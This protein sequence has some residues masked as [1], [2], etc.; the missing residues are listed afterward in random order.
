[1]Q[2]ET[3]LHTI[4]LL[5]GP[6]NSGKTHFCK[7][8]LIPGL[9]K[10]YDKLNIQY[11]SSDDIRRKLNNNPNLGKYDSKMI[12]ASHQA[13]R[14]LYHDLDMVT[15]FP[16]NCHFAIVDTTGL[17]NDFRND[18]IEIAKKNHYNIDLILFNYSDYGNFFKYGGDHKIIERHIKTL[19]TQTLKEL[20]KEYRKRHYI[21]EITN[22]INIKINDIEMYKNNLLDSNKKY[23]IIG[24]VH[25]SVDEVKKLITN[26]GYLIENDLIKNSDTTLNTEII[27]V[28]DLIDK[29]NKTKETVEFF[30]INIDKVKLVSGN[31]DFAIKRL[32][33]GEQSE[34]AYETGFIDQF[35]TSYK[36]LKADQDLKNKFLEVESRMVPYYHYIADDTVSRS[37]YIMHSPC[38]MKFVGKHSWDAIKFQ[39]YMVLDRKNNQKP[40]DIIDI[41]KDSYSMPYLVTGHFAFKDEYNGSRYNNNRL[42]ID[43]GCI[44]GN[45]LTG[46]LLGKKMFYPK[47]FYVS[48][49]KKQ[50][51][52]N[53]SLEYFE[54]PKI[55]EKVLES[56]RPDQIK[57]IQSIVNNKINFISGTISPADRYRDYN[58][59]DLES[60]K[61]GLEY[62]FKFDETM[63]LSIQPKYMGSR[64][65]IYL[66]HNVDSCYAV[67]RNGYKIG[68][69]FMTKIYM[70]LINKFK[71]YMTH[72]KVKMMIIDSELMPWSAIGA[73]LIEKSFKTIDYALNKE[74]DILKSTGFE[75]EYQKLV[76]KMQSTTFPQ[77]Y[78]KKSNKELNDQYGGAVYQTYKDL[79]DEMKTHISVDELMEGAKL[80]H[81]QIEIYGK[82]Q[83]VHIKPF[84]ILKIIYEDETEV[85]PTGQI[86]IF[87]MVSDDTQYVVD[88]SHGFDQCLIEAS[89]YFDKLTTNQ[90]MEG[91]VIKP[92]IISDV[93]MAPFIKVRNPN[94]LTIIYGA[95]YMTEHKYNKLMKNKNIGK[96]IQASINENKLGLKMLETKYDDI[97]MDNHEYIKC[98]VEFFGIEESEKFIDPRL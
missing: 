71:D 48:F 47:F 87:K 82:S 24:D 88:F 18:I 36:V 28:G 23:L 46:V 43:T 60:L 5:V 27:F 56:L 93:N 78:G 89:A 38:N 4:F 50:V 81:E 11:I 75:E 57:R 34:D 66:F 16:I 67:S 84:N 3:Q 64:C 20:G 73:G 59:E 9:N 25:E 54:D 52:F 79:T 13:F 42:M 33:K 12:E 7:N 86:E 96:K 2:F 39:R 83:E 37:F 15:Q 45:K 29:G 63:K 62:Y 31:H 68:H 6:T 14:M 10:A 74:L 90:N 22:E 76:T 80:Y 92:D 44:Y 55:N 35:Y 30:H 49:M 41:N 17:Q 91:I 85:V 51:P 70:E 94:Y 65:N 95:D 26:Y 1:M 53:E 40:R 21:N 61:K 98:L 19:R 72:N 69:D 32:L 58:K 97:T 77:E 8:V